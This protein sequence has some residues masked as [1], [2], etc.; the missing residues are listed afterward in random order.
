MGSVP[1][2]TDVHAVPPGFGMRVLLRSLS[3]IRPRAIGG[4]TLF[5]GYPHGTDVHST[6]GMH[7]RLYLHRAIC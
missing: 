3:K 7:R 1:E 2:F 5:S 4:S 6:P